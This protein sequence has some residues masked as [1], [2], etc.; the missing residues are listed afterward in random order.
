[1]NTHR[2]ASALSGAFLLGSVAGCG[3]GDDAGSAKGPA[4]S[5]NVSQGGIQDMELFRQTIESGQ[6]PSPEMLDAV[7]FFA[8]HAIDLPDA[9][10]GRTLCVHPFL[11]VAP[12]MD[13][14]GN[15]TMAFVAMNTSVDPAT[16]PRPPVHLVYAIE[17]SGATRGLASADVAA[18][19]AGVFAAL[20]PEDRVSLVGLGDGATRVFGER[21]VPGSAELGM[22]TNDVVDARAFPTG[23]TGVDLHGGIATV[24]RLFEDDAEAGFAGAH[25]VVLL[26]SGAHGA[27]ISAPET[28]VAAA[29]GLVREGTAFS[30]VGYGGDYDPEVPVEIGSLG[31][32]TYSYASDNAQLVELLGVEGATHLVPLA[33]NL[34]I[35]VQAAPGYR[36]GR[37]YG[38]HRATRTDAAARID[39]PA[40]FV[41]LRDGEEE[42]GGSRR[43]GGGGL[44]VELVADRAAGVTIGANAPAFTVVSHW[45]EAGAPIDASDALVNALAP[46][47]NPDGMW[48]SFSDE[49]RVK[50]FMMLNMYLAFHATLDLYDGGDCAR[51]LGAIDAMQ[52]VIGGW[53]GKYDDA[54]IADDASL[55]L[56]LRSNIENACRSATE[57]NVTPKPPEWDY[58]PSCMFL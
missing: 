1:M 34:S 49:V 51:S 31:A 32:G 23:E 10:C 13:R 35:E 40:V 29:E 52:P 58:G 3:A 38:A 57:V 11:A 4:G 17:Q 9:T 43:G 54:D 8:E 53:Q 56:R 39:L 20:R 6:V 19:L 18:A 5:I 44:F 41:G 2:F 55:M 7:G 28:I 24:R 47:Q 15:W 14:V 50:A 33:Q 37:I 22:R 26:T 25:R 30:V 12:R 42:V 16:L 21:L 48:P 46:G 36:I 45:D 27:G